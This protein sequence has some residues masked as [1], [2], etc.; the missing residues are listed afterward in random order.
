M[1]YRFR[2]M[3][4]SYCWVNDEQQLLRDDDG[5][6]L[7]VVGSWSDIS[8]RKKL[9]DAEIAAQTRLRHLLS[10]LPAVIY[11]F[12]AVG[13]FAPTFVSENIKKV[14]GYEQSD[15]LEDPG[16]WRDRVHPDDLA[17]VEAEV[18]RLFRNGVHVMEYRFRRMD[19]SYCW[20]SDEQQLLRDDDG[21]PLEVVGSWSDISERKKLE[22]AEIAAQTRLRHLLS[23]LPAVIYSF[24]ATGDYAPTY[25]SENLKDLLGYECHEYLESPDFWWR[26]VHHDDRAS[27][28]SAFSELFEHGRVNLEYRFRRQDGT[29]SWVGDEQRLIEDENGEPIAVVGSWSD[30]SRRK[31]A[32]LALQEVNQRIAESIQ[33]ASRIQT[34]ILPP[35]D[36]LSMLTAEHFLIWE[37]RDVVGGDFFWF[38]RVDGGY[39][40]ILGDCTG[41]G[42]PGAF[43]TLIVCGLLDQIVPETGPDYDP[44]RILG[45]LHRRLQKMLGQDCDDGHTDDGLDAGACFVNEVGRSL[46][47]AGAH[48]SLWR[49]HDG[50]VEELKGNRPGL[51]YRQYPEGTEFT[52]NP[53]RAGVWSGFLYDDR[54]V[55][56]PNWRTSP[57]C[58]WQEALCQVHCRASPRRSVQTR[59]YTSQISYGVSGERNSSG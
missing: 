20:V 18:S 53:N 30:I 13:D 51:G 8:E 39:L 15:Y 47:F 40:I 41:H 58:I 57:S 22:D 43:M 5:N 35:R 1:E 11:S 44:A 34:A 23:S 52:S 50:H 29:Y 25:V 37:P 17:R 59:L 26:C 46:M 48:I 19:G 9:E 32:E 21:N 4:G 55:D 56:R 54:R 45:R 3:D 24:K 12:N 16:F 49:A 14:L 7:E 31:R 10:S 27:V 28:E 42:V 33:Y 36:A 38:H 6:P 2:R